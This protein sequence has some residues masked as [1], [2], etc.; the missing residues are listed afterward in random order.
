MSEAPN[1]NKR[2]ILFALFF[3]FCVIALASWVTFRQGD[4]TTPETPSTKNNNDPLKT[5]FLQYAPTQSSSELRLLEERSSLLDPEP[6]VLQ[7]SWNHRTRVRLEEYLPTLPIL[8]KE[9]RIPTK[10]ETYA[11]TPAPLNPE[12]RNTSVYLKQT[13]SRKERLF[14]MKAYLL[15]TNPEQA[16][17]SGEQ[18]PAQQKNFSLMVLYDVG[19]PGK[20]KVYALEL[21]KKPKHSGNALYPPLIGTLWIHPTGMASPL[22]VQSTPGTEAISDTLIAGIERKIPQLGLSSGYYYVEAF[23]RE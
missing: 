10:L 6:L 12:G 11:Y 23:Y 4:T 19:D 13:L 7:T 17:R 22:M 3:F 14:G 16:T 20:R 2:E 15:H 8:A 5:S 18:K 9:Q 1:S 21:K